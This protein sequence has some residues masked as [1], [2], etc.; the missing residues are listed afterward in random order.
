MAITDLKPQIARLPEQPGVYLYFNRAGETIYVGKARRLRDRVRSYLG[1]HGSH[2]KTDALLDEVHALEVIVTDSVVEALALENDLIKQR[3]PRYNVMLR[4]DKSYPYLKLTTAEACPRL[5]VARRV[6]RDGH[7]YAGPFLPASLARRTIKLTHKLFGIRSCREVI[8]GDRP[9]PCLEYDIHRCIA[10][11]VASICSA[12]AYRHAVDRAAMF[13][14]GRNEELVGELRH[15][16]LEAAGE[17]RYEQAAHLRD[18][19]ATIETLRDRKQKMATPRLGDRDAFGL[20]LGTAGVTVQVFQ[21][22]GGRVIDRIDLSGDATSGAASEAEIIE[23]ALQ[24]FYEAQPAPPEIH[25]AVAPDDVESLESWLSALAGRKVRVVVPQRGDK[26]ALLELATRNAALAYD[27]R[28]NEGGIAHYDAL[29][30]LRG[31]LGLASVPQRID[32]FDISTI[33][34]S[35]TV[36]SMVVCEQGKMRRGEYRKFRVL[37]RAADGGPDDFAAMEE[38]VQRRY[39]RVAD[40]DGPWPDLIVID[41]GYGQLS[42]AYTALERLGLAHL[43]A[44]GLAKKE[45]LI[46]TRDRPEPIALPTDSPALLLLQRIRDEAHRFAVTFHRKA[47]AMRDL[48]SE[49]DGIP[50]IGP[51]R[52]KRLLTQFGSVAGVRRAA[53][54]DLEAA[55]GARAAAAVLQW[56]DSTRS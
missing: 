35:D 9:R 11:C 29:D 7:L 27:T 18:A 28:F 17:E 45:E 34:G 22:R 10:P 3:S 49:L 25:V 15:E 14:E 41:G 42:A 40:D 55:V 19:I 56:F 20:K 13:L 39:A 31:T 51:G 43:V 16:M 4:D 2:P 52:R 54:E 23:A 24:Q 47:R 44:V 6:E 36:A 30:I 8:T 5:H 37:A 12:D 33:Q 32:C 21:M 48:R 26:R 46:V 1:A 50:G 38:V 53:R